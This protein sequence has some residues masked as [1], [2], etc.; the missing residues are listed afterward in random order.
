VVSGGI[1]GLATFYGFDDGVLG[2]ASG[3]AEA[4]AG[5]ADGLVV[6]GIDGKAEKA[7]LPRRFFGSVFGKDRAEERVLSD[8]DCVRN[9]YAAAGGVVDG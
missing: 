8:S 6:T 9:G 4:V 3:D 2:A 7:V 5:N 1:G